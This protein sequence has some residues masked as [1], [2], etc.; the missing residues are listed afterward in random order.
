VYRALR[1]DYQKSHFSDCAAQAAREAGWSRQ[2]ST[3]IYALATPTG[4]AAA[5][6]LDLRL[7]PHIGEP[8]Q[9][10]LKFAVLLLFI[11][12]AVAAVYER[13][14]IQEISSERYGQYRDEIEPCAS[15]RRRSPGWPS[16]RSS[17]KQKR[18]RRGNSR[19]SA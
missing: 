16:G 1:L 2:A 17:G 5:V 7:Y 10:G 11:A 12:N 19:S 14:G 3:L 13:A 9:A 18:S 15:G 4:L 6:Y 8:V